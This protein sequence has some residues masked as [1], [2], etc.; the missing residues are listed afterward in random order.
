M[1]FPFPYIGIRTY[2]YKANPRNL[3]GITIKTD[4]FYN[5]TVKTPLAMQTVTA[6]ND[7]PILNLSNTFEN[8]TVFFPLASLDPEN[9][10]FYINTIY[11]NTIFYLNLQLI[12]SF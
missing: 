1:L 8:T 4:P 6:V 9:F 5:W 2:A 11:K 12:F 10:I 7:L 3:N